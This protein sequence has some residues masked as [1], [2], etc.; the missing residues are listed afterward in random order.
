MEDPKV[1]KYMEG[2]P[3]GAEGE[4]GEAQDPKMK[5]KVDAY[6]SVLTE[7]LHSPKSRDSV[8]DVLMKD[9][10][11]FNTVP[12]LAVSVNDMGVNLMK[13]SN[14]EVPF[15][16]QLAASTY[17][18]EDL[19]HLGYAAA[20]WDQ[21]DDTDIA[22]I[23]EDTLQIVI[24][25]GLKDGSIDPIQL[26]METEPMLN[27]NQKAAGQ[28]G[29]QEAGLDSAPSQGAMIDQHTK[30]KLRQAEGRQAKKTAVNAQTAQSQAMAGPPQGQQQGG[31]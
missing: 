6:V 25:R 20:G 3:S 24:E 23:Y 29:A 5:S 17:L 11:P 31:K 13:Q 9:S 15:S 26:Q 4:E 19:I 30:G 8:T 14:V 21:L 16:V 10:D 18:I 2:V 7:L 12:Q 27:E 22:G 28:Y 1:D